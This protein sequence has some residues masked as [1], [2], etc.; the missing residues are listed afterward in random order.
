[1]I[2]LNE[3]FKFKANENSRRVAFAR[4]SGY[5]SADNEIGEKRLREVWCFRKDASK[6]CFT[7][8]IPECSHRKARKI[9]FCAII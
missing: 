4:Y 3:T 9:I 2:D 6:P 8:Y 5:Y 7:L 1:M